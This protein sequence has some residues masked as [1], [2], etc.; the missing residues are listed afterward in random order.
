[1]DGRTDRRTGRWSLWFLKEI[2]FHREILKEIFQTPG[3]RRV[4][5]VTWTPV[6]QFPSLVYFHRRRG[7]PQSLGSF[8]WLFLKT[9]PLQNQNNSPRLSKWSNVSKFQNLVPAGL[10]LNSY[11]TSKLNKYLHRK[12]LYPCFDNFSCPSK[13]DSG[14][15]SSK[16]EPRANNKYSIYSTKSFYNYMA[17]RSMQLLIITCLLTCT[18]QSM[19]R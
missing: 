3:P 19:L 2:Q 16:V 15:D 12:K 8:S 17:K 13:N 9:N 18:Y 7:L 6:H 1:M 14:V 11:S 4:Q 10:I 5:D